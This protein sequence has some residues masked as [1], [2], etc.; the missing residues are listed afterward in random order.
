MREYL[1][2]AAL[3]IIGLL[4]LA[5]VGCKS[6]PVAATVNGEKVYIEDINKQLANLEKQHAGAFQGTEG[7]KMKKDFTKRILDNLIVQELILQEAKKKKLT[8]SDAEVDKKM[9]QVKQMFKTDAEYKK[10]LKDQGMS[11]KDLTK[12]LTNQIMMEKMSNLITG[13]PKASEAEIKKQYEANKAQYQEPE[14]V[15][16]A[17][18]LVDSEET[19]KDIKNQ[20]DKGGDFAELAKK[21]SKDTATKDKGGELGQFKKGTMVKEFEEAAFGMKAGKVSDPIKSQF[22]FHLIKVIE[23]IPARQKTLN[24]VKKEIS[25][26]IKK[27]IAS[28]KFK[29]YSDGLRAKANVKVQMAL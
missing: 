8:A 20:V 4:L 16:A 21:Y 19:A 15:K 28:D 3:I 13:D 1:K 18:I 17:H 9:A 12:N 29:K 22:G 10:A 6:K 7:A 2:A 26:Q 14:Q 27:T 24:E 11:E 23:K 25:D 5:P